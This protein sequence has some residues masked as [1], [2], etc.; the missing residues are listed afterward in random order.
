MKI[1][2]A[3]LLF[4]VCLVVFHFWRAAWTNTQAN[5]AKCTTCECKEV[6]YWEPD[7]HPFAYG[8]KDISQPTPT[9]IRH[10]LLNIEAPGGCQK[11]PT[12]PGGTTIQKFIYTP[13]KI[14]P[15]RPNVLIYES[16]PPDKNG[17]AETLEFVGLLKCTP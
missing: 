3:R 10:A 14:C 17:G 5:P 11:L 6:Y 1:T 2:S 12:V 16:D 13:N 4:L 15:R 9:K 7:N 8:W